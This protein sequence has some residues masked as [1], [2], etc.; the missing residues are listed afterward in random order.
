MKKINIC[1]RCPLPCGLF[2][3]PS[4]LRGYTAI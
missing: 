3:F 4:L 2:L 1:I